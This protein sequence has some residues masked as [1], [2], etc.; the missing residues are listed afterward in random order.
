MTAK[1]VIGLVLAVSFMLV[2]P[3]LVDAQS[4]EKM[5]LGE[6]SKKADL[7]IGEMRG[8]K[9]TSEARL[10]EARAEK[11]MERMDCINEALMALK[12]VLNLAETYYYDFQAR[13]KGSDSKGGRTEY[14]KVK[15]VSAK[16]MDL[17]AQIRSCGGPSDQGVTEGEPVIAWSNDLD[18]PT[19]DPV[20]DREF[21][22]VFLARPSVASPYH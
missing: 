4:K 3:G 14:T 18:L 5:S 19:G 16:I 10:R 2:H 17:D 8:I 15:I 1:N 6:M 20:E 11:D 12:G 13:V 21:G 9:D 22:E 7:L